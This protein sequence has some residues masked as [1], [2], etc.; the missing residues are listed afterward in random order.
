MSNNNP[1]YQRYRRFGITHLASKFRNFFTARGVA[2]AA[3]ASAFSVTATVA[4]N[5]LTVTAHG[6]T[7][8]DGPFRFSA[9]TGT[10]STVSTST[11]YWV[12][13]VVDANTIRVSP[14]FDLRS[15]L[16]VSAGVGTA[17]LTRR[18]AGD[19][20]MFSARRK[21]LERVR[22]ATDIDNV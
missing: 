6:R 21:G 14:F 2:L 20:L 18:T 3:S 10:L 12:S 17:T 7:V 11:D 9:P 16:T 1:R 22:A 15:D 5:G 4:S 13:A 8:G 19:A